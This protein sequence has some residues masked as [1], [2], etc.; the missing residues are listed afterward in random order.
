[1]NNAKNHGIPV[2][3]EIAS[4]T[5]LS[6]ADMEPV[7]KKIA[8]EYKGRLDI[9]FIFIDLPGQKDIALK[10]GFRAIPTQI[11]LDKNGKEFSRHVGI[12]SY[13]DIKTVLKQTGLY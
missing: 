1:L 3:I 8:H 10:F 9:I 7:L 12:F 11:F 2:V 5:C 6:C 4:K 13:K